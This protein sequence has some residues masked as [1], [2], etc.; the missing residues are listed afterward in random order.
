MT[1]NEITKYITDVCVRAKA[2]SRSTSNL[3]A[4][5]KNGILLDIAKNIRNNADFIIEENKKDIQ[6]ADEAGVTKALRDRLLL[7]YDRLSGMAVSVEDIAK[8]DDPIGRVESMSVRPSG[9]R[10]GQMRV[11]VGVIAVIFESRPNVTTDIAALAIKSGNAAILRGGKE[12]LYSN[13]AL[14]TVIKK[15]FQNSSCPEDAVVLIDK[16]EHE[17][18]A[19]LLKMNNYI[20]IVIPRGGEKLIGMV[21][22]EST[23]PVIKHDKGV[24]HTFIDE[25]ADPEMAVSI[26]VNAKV[27]RPGVCNAMETLLFHNGFRDKKKVL[28]ALIE[29]GVELRA[30][31]RTQKLIPDK[32]KPATEQDW[33]EEYLDLILSV[34]IVDTMD[35]AMEH[36]YKYGSGHSEAIVTS[37]YFNSERF[38][39]EVDS[40]AVFV[41]SSTRFHDGGEFGLGAEIGISTQKLHARGAMGVMGLTCLKYVIYGSGQV[42]N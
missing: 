30:C 34:K 14:Y 24:C 23:I 32:L 20:D 7:N 8:M 40:S 22:R 28:E 19:Q 16:T 36:I 26:S 10:V 39:R 4:S 17:I 15:S 13:K 18:V 35:E 12:S 29:K 41:N 1:G 11:P 37:D 3:T 33:V 21:T 31:E 25:S 38:L 6:A 27:Q 9:I 5:E 2:S 42:R